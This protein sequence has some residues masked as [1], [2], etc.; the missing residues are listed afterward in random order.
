MRIELSCDLGEAQDDDGREIERQLWELIDA[1][2]VACGGHA[3]DR[4]SM[5]EAALLA[6]RNGVILGAHPSYPDREHFGR[7]TLEISA[8]ELFDSLREQ[9]TTLKDVAAEHGVML[10]RVKP[11]GALYNDAHGDKNRAETIVDAM[12]SVDP[13]LALV[14]PGT[15][16]M[17][18]VAQERGVTVVREAF[19][20]RRYLPDGSLTPRIEPDALLSVPDAAAQAER[21]ATDRAVV[22]RNGATIPL[23]FETVCIH[24]DMAG[25]VDRARAVRAA[26][27]RVAAD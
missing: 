1:A 4:D 6:A 19:A 5:H 23:H 20:D 26:L 8:P 21:I 9:I 10:R 14:A 25:S 12:M 7:R 27:A 11:H 13:R 18:R 2:N 17:A 22:A 15:S 24:S 16:E 3:G